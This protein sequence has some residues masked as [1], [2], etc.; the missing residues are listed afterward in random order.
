MVTSAP[1][2][3]ELVDVL[4][5]DKI[6][7]RMPLSVQ[8][9]AQIRVALE[10]MAQRTPGEYQDIDLVPTDPKDNPVAAAALEAQV[11][12]VVSL[13]DRDLL[14]LK[15]FHLSGHAVIQIVL[16]ED[17]LKLLS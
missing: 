9:I 3:D 15:A 10:Q 2:L 17:F 5:R 1:I 11:E 6:Q 12:Y 14:G 7:R 8:D 4:A 16:P 13:D